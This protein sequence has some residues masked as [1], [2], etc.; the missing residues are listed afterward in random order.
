MSKKL[1]IIIGVVVFLIALRLILP[2]IVL[3]YVNNKLAN[4]TE[5]YGHVEDIDLALIRGA[6]VINDIRI[7]KWNEKKKNDTIPFFT[8]SEIDLSVEWS[9]IFEGKIVGEIDVYDPVL[10]FVKG[11]HKDE[12]VKADTADFR[13]LI[14]D[15]MPLT[16]NRFEINNGRIH[17]IDVISN[18]KLDISLKN[19]HVIATN[20]TNVNDSAKLLPAHAEAS[21]QAYEGDFTLKMDFNALNKMPTFDMTAELKNL[22]LALLTDFFKAYGNFDVKK[23]RLGLYT[24]FAAKEGTFGGYVKPL[25]KDM[26]VV[27]GEGD[28]KEQIW[29]LMVAGTAKLLENKKT[30]QIATNVPI[31]GRFDKPDTNLWRAVSYLLR[32]AFLNALKPSIDNTINIKQLE[33]DGKK[34]F[35]EKVFGNKKEKKKE[36]EKK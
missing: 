6:Y 26:E 11:A 32:N 8:S 36:G 19:L 23:G 2:Y 9:A 17:Y 33:E 5:Y 31:N 12:D 20:L 25:L 1:K 13:Q 7:V 3:K 10:N 35:L 24:E 21:G 4:L 28:L 22:N 27:K 18:P 30:D 14:K 16:V 15:L 29:E 34:T